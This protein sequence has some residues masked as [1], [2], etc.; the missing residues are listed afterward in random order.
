[1]DIFNRLD[2]FIFLILYIAYIYYNLV[3]VDFKSLT[4]STQLRLHLMYIIPLNM[5][6]SRIFGFCFQILIL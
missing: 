6:L 1:M 4:F 2:L 5:R 3:T